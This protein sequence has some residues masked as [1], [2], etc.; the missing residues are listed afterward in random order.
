MKYTA[1]DGKDGDKAAQNKAEKAQEKLDERQ[2]LLQSYD[3]ITRKNLIEV[4]QGKLGVDFAVQNNLL[5]FQDR[6]DNK[7]TASRNIQKRNVVD[8]GGNWID[9]EFTPKMETV[10]IKS[11]SAAYFR[12]LERRPEM[13]DVFQLGN[14]LVWVTPSGKALI[15][16]RG[17]GLETMS[18]ADIDRLFTA[19]TKIAKKIEKK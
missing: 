17:A 13:K 1:G 15:I 14:Y 7:S 9:D 11:Q 10:T 2:A 4:Q 16:D 19:P 8:V 5:R 12:M 18:D 6:L 3:A